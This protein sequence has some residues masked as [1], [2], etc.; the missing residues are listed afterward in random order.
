[1]KKMKATSTKYSEFFAAATAALREIHFCTFRSA[2]MAILR[3]KYENDP[4]GLGLPLPTPECQER[5]RRVMEKWMEE[6]TKQAYEASSAAVNAAVDNILLNADF[7]TGV[8]DAYFTH[9]QRRIRGKAPRGGGRPATVDWRVSVKEL[10]QKNKH[11]NTVEEMMAKLVSRGD[12]RL[13][14]DVVTVMNGLA[15][16]RQVSTRNFR[17]QLSGALK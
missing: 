2:L 14:G 11:L 1:M 7:L 16:D 13:E 5:R 8:G 17:K 12:I 9:R 10:R 4:P 3:D 15:P 6:P